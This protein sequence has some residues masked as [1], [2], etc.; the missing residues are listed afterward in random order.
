MED[1]AVHEVDQNMDGLPEEIRIAVAG[2]EVNMTQ[3]KK[4]RAE[5]EK[6]RDFSRRA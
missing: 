5:V 4:F 3:A 2:N 1:H 6:A